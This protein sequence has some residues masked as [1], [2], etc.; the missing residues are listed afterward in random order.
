MSLDGS[1]RDRADAPNPWSATPKQIDAWLAD[2]A[3][4]DGVLFWLLQR[5]QPQFDELLLCRGFAPQAVRAW[6]LEGV[7][8]DRL[9]RD[10]G[11]TGA[12]E[13]T[14]AEMGVQSAGLSASAHALVFV[15][16]ESV[17]RRLAWTGV[18]VREGDAF[19]A[20]ER[21]MLCALVRLWQATFNRPAEHGLSRLLVGADN[22]LIHADPA[23]HLTL[24]RTGVPAQRLVDEVRQVREQRWPGAGD[25]APHD[26]AIELGDRPVWI[27][28]RRARAID[29]PGAH[30]WLLELRPLAPGELPAVG[31]LAD[32][33]I[34]R[35][36]AFIHDHFHE[37]PSLAEIARHVHVSPFH[38][39]RVFSRQVGVS[40]KQY[41][42]MKQMQSARW[43]LRSRRTP[44]S[45]IA[46]ETG[47]S[48]HGHFTATFGR[49][50]GVSPTD[51]RAR[52][53]R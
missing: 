39:H 43:M 24:L 35:S 4:C 30:H 11:E 28:S 26:M 36:L 40:P 15:Q 21:A 12:A 46:R 7:R 31:V 27:V 34:A 20:T 6:A 52:A 42:Q 14:I 5:D 51:Y 38:F 44:I 33:R 8:G 53:G 48:S 32:E 23:C 37:G 19:A 41:L 1:D 49:V 29:L 9:F 10:A 22:R 45:R 3:A 16:P 2:A 18:F 50:V 13:G 47:F 25:D 17:E